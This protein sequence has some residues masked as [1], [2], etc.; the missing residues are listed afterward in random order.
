MNKLEY[1]DEFGN[2]VEEIQETDAEIQSEYEELL[3]SGE[4]DD[5]HKAMNR[6]DSN[7][8]GSGSGDLEQGDEVTGEGEVNV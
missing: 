4:F 2:D 6:V 8:G 7:A 3:K 1:K 5:S